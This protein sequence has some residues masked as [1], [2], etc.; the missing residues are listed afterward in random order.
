[1]K[2][3][4]KRLSIYSLPLEGL[5]VAIV[6]VGICSAIYRWTDDCGYECGDQYAVPGIVSRESRRTS[7]VV[8]GIGGG[9]QNR[10]DE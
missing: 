1:M 8:A 9:D 3:A 10:T 5:E 4:A 7:P 6:I 2:H